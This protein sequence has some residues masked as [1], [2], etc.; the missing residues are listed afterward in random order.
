MNIKADSGMWKTIRVLAYLSFIAFI[1]YN[2]A[3]KPDWTEVKAWLYM[4]AFA[5]AWE[6]GI[7]DKALNILKKLTSSG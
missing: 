3:S 1:L 5:I 6:L 4:G 7:E 2:T